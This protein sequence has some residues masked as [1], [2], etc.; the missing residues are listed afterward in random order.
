VKEMKILKNEFNLRTH[1]ILIFVFFA[2]NECFMGILYPSTVSLYRCSFS[3]SVQHILMK[4]D[5]S[6]YQMGSQRKG[7]ILSKLQFK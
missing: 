6:T 1:F 4:C 5:I 3:K 2:H 7:D